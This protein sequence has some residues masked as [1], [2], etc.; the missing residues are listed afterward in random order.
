VLFRADAPQVIA[1]VLWIFL[2]GSVA[3]FAMTRAGWWLG[4]AG[5]WLVVLASLGAL[6]WHDHRVR[7]PD[8]HAVVVIAQDVHLR[9]GNAETFP[10]RLDGHY[11]LP[12]G[13]EARE[14]TSRGGWVQ[15]KLVSGIIGWVPETAVLRTGD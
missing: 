3:R 15:I 11:R 9:K 8:E 14:L 10:L 1:G 12:R 2:C 5:V 7:T 4:L 6:W 13:V